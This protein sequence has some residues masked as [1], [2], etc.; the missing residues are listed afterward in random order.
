M[1][2]NSSPIIPLALA[3][4]TAVGVAGGI[5]WLGQERK[6][7][8]P[9]QTMTK[10]APRW[11]ASS[12]GRVEPKGG[13]IKLSA[14]ASGRIE[15]V[16][17]KVN[18]AVKAG[19][20]LVRL[21][22]ADAL[23]RVR[24]AE[25]EVGVRKRERDTETKVPALTQ[26]RR[27]AEDALSNTE[28]AISQ[29]HQDLDS[30]FL[31]RHADPKSVTAAQI[32]AQRK[33]L[34]NVQRRLQ[35]ER[36]ALARAKAAT[37]VPLPTRLEAGLTASRSDLS[38]AE[39]ALERTRLRAPVDGTVLQVHAHQGEIA[40]TSPEQPLIVVGDLTALR[41]RVEVEERD[42]ARVE[43]GQDVVIKADAYPGKEFTGKVATIARA[44]RPPK[45]APKGPKRPADLDTLE[46]MVD[47]DKGSPLLPGMRVDVFFKERPVAQSTPTA[48]PGV[49]PA[50]A[51]KAKAASGNAAAAPK[52]T[53]TT[54]SGSGVIVPNV[55]A[56]P[57]M[58]ATLAASPAEAPKV[59]PPLP[60]PK[61]AK[62]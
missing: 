17:V 52:G 21:D 15:N 57:V 36:D 22:D 19:D 23:A 43:V 27:D 50:E 40:A 60:Q 1:S 38:L 10:P 39:A 5:Q 45:L 59:L 48:K 41:I 30:L 53:V 62:N 8:S 33:V 28:R 54:N 3:A 29:A 61:R 7:E 2:S 16:L 12:S 56:Q 34:D 37:D 26:A 4:L 44:M 32:D 24:G 42:V 31:A 6:A 14:L 11:A 46:V 25:A 13:E 9:K 55:S 49:A 20:L 58:P 47:V 51:S 18:D 35:P